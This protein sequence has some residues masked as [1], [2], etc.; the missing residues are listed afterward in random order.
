VKPPV[1]IV[2]HIASGIVTLTGYAYMFGDNERE[3]DITSEAFERSLTGNLL[4]RLGFGGPPIASTD[5][6]TMVAEVDGTGLK[7]IARFPDRELLGTADFSFTFKTITQTWTD[8]HRTITGL[9]LVD[10][11]LHGDGR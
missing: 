3:L 5:D 8:G 6:G 10:I 11:I 4:L 2:H 1:D 7:V 9:K